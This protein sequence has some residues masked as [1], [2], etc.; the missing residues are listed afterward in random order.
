MP[1]RISS[2]STKTKATPKKNSNSTG[3]T[4][5][6]ALEKQLAQREA[7]IARLFAENLLLVKDKDLRATELQII[8]NIGQI[9]TEG[10]DLKSAIKSVGDR[11]RDALELKNIA[12]TIANQ[13]MD[14]I[15][16]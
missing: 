3:V 14:N 13:G 11:L 5:I 2:K 4:K 1:P 6:H 9:L 15:V 16:A 7:E 12:I 10:G 8:N